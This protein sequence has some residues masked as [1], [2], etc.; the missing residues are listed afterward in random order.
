M[1]PHSCSFTDEAYHVV[2][3]CVFLKNKIHTRTHSAKDS[4]SSSITVIR[5]VP[6]PVPYF[7]MD[8][9]TPSHPRKGCPDFNWELLWRS[10]EWPTHLSAAVKALENCEL[11]Q[12]AREI[13]TTY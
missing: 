10:V 6:K 3:V 4:Y 2:C 7:F 8:M 1:L 9:S 5:L 12:G 11:E 13:I